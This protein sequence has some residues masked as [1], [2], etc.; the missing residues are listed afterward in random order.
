MIGLDLGG[1]DDVDGG[2][3]NLLLGPFQFGRRRAG[4][5]NFKGVG[6]GVA[7][8]V[9]GRAPD[10]N[11]LPR[12]QHAVVGGSGACLQGGG[13]NIVGWPRLADLDRR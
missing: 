12:P 9:E 13:E 11:K 6:K 10:D 5:A 2:A 4:L 3:V 1:D 8:T 7:Q